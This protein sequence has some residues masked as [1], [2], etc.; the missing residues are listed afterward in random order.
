ME[1]DGIC[2]GL[3]ELSDFSTKAVK[4]EPCWS[5]ERYSRRAGTD[6]GYEITQ[7]CVA[8]PHSV[9]VIWFAECIAQQTQ[10]GVSIFAA[11]AF[12]EMVW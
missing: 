3:R 4:P 2:T 6:T 5:S 12:H 8:F 9:L 7:S 1:P 10:R 11:A